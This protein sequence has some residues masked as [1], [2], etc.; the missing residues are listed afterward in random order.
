[1]PAKSNNNICLLKI[2]YPFQ[3]SVDYG[4]TKFTHL[5]L[6]A[7]VFRLVKLYTTWKNKKNIACLLF[8]RS[9]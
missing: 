8:Q 4:N 6:K 5:A 2:L 7:S 1:M 9:Q 3:S